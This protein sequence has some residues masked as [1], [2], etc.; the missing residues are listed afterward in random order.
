M[1]IAVEFWQLVMLLV[2]FLAFVA[3]SGKVL[4]AQIDKRLD[5]RFAAQEVTRVESQRHWNAQFAALEQAG[6]DEASQWQRVDRDLLQLRAELPL[7]YVR[8]EDYIRGQTVI[9]AKLDAV[10]AKIENLQLKGSRHD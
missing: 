10:A 5:E 8:R 4:L 1:T 7:H 3:A 2:A 9:E 6:R